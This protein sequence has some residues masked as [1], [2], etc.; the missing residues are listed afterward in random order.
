[1]LEAPLTLYH[2]DGC[3]L[4]ELAMTLLDGLNIGYRTQDICEQETLAERYGVLIPVLANSLGEE[5]CWPFDE[6][7]VK[8]FTGA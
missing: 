7:Q 3:H 8:R 4:C 6:Q 1:M 2:T 5:L